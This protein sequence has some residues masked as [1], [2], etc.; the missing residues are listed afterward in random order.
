MLPVLTVMVV[1]AEFALLQA[2]H[3]E[4]VTD[5]CPVGWGH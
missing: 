3:G 5:Y 1:L 2:L 4:R